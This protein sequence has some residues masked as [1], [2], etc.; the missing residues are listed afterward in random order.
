M[1]RGSASH[2]SGCDGGIAEA[3]LFGGDTVYYYQTGLEPDAIKVGPGWIGMIGMILILH[4]GAFQL[5]AFAWQVAG[6]DAKPIMDA[7]VTFPQVLQVTGQTELLERA[8]AVRR[9]VYLR[10]PAVAPL[11]RLQVALLSRGGEASEQEPAWHDIPVVVV[12]AM[13][14][15]AEDRARLNGH[16]E[17]V[18][19]KGAYERDQLLAE[20][21][22]LLAAS[23]SPSARSEV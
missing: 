9:T 2:N 15:T 20:V 22:A 12:T 16:V 10:N 17:K 1:P 7:F 4:F 13:D 8:G 23:V 18:V 3:L 11:S 19:Q 14:L 6:L 5:L 21:R